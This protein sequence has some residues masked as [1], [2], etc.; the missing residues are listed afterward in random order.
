MLK[1][2]LK[3]ENDRLRVYVFISLLGG[4]LL[5]ITN[6]V[7]IFYVRE[8]VREEKIILLPAGISKP[9]EFRNSRLPEDY[10]KEMTRLI[11]SLTLNYHPA[12][13][14]LGYDD[15]LAYFAPEA[16]AGAR[17]QLYHL[18]DLAESTQASSVFYPQEISVIHRGDNTLEG[19]ID[20]R[21]IHRKQFKNAAGR[22]ET[23]EML[24]TWTIKYRTENMRFRIVEINPTEEG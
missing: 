20:T 8:A 10:L 19:R 14:R 15:L 21:G 1:Q 23:E 13:V 24:E 2:V 22:V 4:L 12:S 17:E 18:A 5:I 9:L 7:N 11:M 16:Y 6:F 3:F